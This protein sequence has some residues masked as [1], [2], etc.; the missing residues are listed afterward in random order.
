LVLRLIVWIG[1]LIFVVDLPAV[2]VQSLGE[3]IRDGTEPLLRYLR[4]VGDVDDQH[5]NNAVALHGERPHIGKIAR[6]AADPDGASGG[7]Y[8]P[9]CPGAPSL[10]PYSAVVLSTAEGG[11]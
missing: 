11:G 7:T 2:L 4:T 5:A 3:R 6:P 9:L 10:A 8:L 1:F